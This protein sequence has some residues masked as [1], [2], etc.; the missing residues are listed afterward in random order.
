MSESVRTIKIEATGLKAIQQ[1]LKATK[2]ALAEATDPEEIK[3]LSIAAADL[4]SQIEDLNDEIKSFQGSNFEQ[5][6][7]Q[8]GKVGTSIKNLDFE[9]AVLQSNTL[10]TLSQRMTFK[11]AIGGVKNLGTT[12]INLGKALLTNPLFL[13]GAI[14]AAVVVAIY[15]LLDSLGL[16]KKMM[17]IVGAAIDYVIGLFKSLTDWLG[18]TN[19]AAKDA[20]EETAKA[21]EESADRQKKASQT[22]IQSLDNKIRMAKLEGKDVTELEREKRKELE[23]TA[24]A[25]MKADQA[26]FKSALLNGDLTKEEIAELKEKARQS[27]LA[28]EQTLADTKYFEAEIRKAKKDEK[29]KEDEDNKKAAEQASKD[30]EAKRKEAEAKRK[31][32]EEARIQ[33]QRVTRD[34]ELEIMSAGIDKEIALNEEKYKR[35]IEDTKRNEKLTQK[36]KDIIIAQYQTL[37][38]ENELKLRKEVEDKRKEEE[39]KAQEEYSKLIFN[40]NSSKT[41]QEIQKIEQD[42]AIKLDLLKKQLTEGLITQ[43]QFDAAEIALAEDKQNKLN[44]ISAGPG[45]EMDPL[46]A[47]RAKAD[48]Q[49]KI[50]KEYFEL[51]LIDEIEYANRRKQIEEDLQNEIQRLEEETAQQKRDNVNNYLGIAT[52][53]ISAISSLMETSMNNEIKA[54]EGNEAKQEQLRKKAF[55]QQKKMQIAAAFINMAQGIISG[56]GA[57]FPMN[58]AMPI[59]AGVTGLANIAKIK[60]TTYEGG[61]GGAAATPTTPS[62]PS[63]MDRMG[64]SFNFQGTGGG[65]NNVQAG[66]PQPMAIT[67]QNEVS[68]SETE[69]TDTQKTVANLTNSAKL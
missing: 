67:I 22:V 59:L 60:S 29:I 25:Q 27:R 31:A 2:N 42:N 15:K 65:A 11:E 58:I 26:K 38:S 23:K 45:G 36:E 40:L 61:G 5:V 1:E 6:S 46:Q 14:I 9:K 51:G 30:A 21:Y 43:E 47:A 63:S 44:Q 48:E 17:E 68:I 41:E 66:G 56:L 53:G 50:Q 52:Q 16:I 12:F 55:E 13:I 3:Q 19:N 33:A 24:Q 10:I 20:A 54:A 32:Y 28:Y 35:L 39:L 7:G 62:T 37:R 57:P 69:V 64:P 8:I 18:I 49:L 34:L 4:K